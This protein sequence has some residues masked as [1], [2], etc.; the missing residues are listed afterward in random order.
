[1]RLYVEILFAEIVGRLIPAAILRFR[2]AQDKITIEAE[3]QLDGVGIV[4]C[5]RARF[6]RAL[7][8]RNQRKLGRIGRRNA[9]PRYA[10]LQIDCDAELFRDRPD[11]FLRW[12][13][14]SITGSRDFLG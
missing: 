13:W 9:E 12:H 1:M 14:R 4:E 6:H 7:H 3:R 2:E 8:I 5:F 11:A 10:A